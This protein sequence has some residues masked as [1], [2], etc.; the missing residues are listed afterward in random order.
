MKLPFLKLEGLGNNYIFVEAKK[1]SRLNMKKL[2]VSICD[3]KSGI[4]ADGLII[5]D[6]AIEPFRMRI[7]NNDGSEV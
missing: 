1:V 4:G 2:A 5:L 7:F 3:I 6:T